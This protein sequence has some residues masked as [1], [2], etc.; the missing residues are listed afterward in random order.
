MAAKLHETKD[1]PTAG[2]GPEIIRML[3]FASSVAKCRLVRRLRSD[4][5]ARSAGFF[6]DSSSEPSL[7]RPLILMCPSITACSL[8]RGIEA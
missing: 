6:T 2:L 5:T 1:L 7:A 4:S 3:F 8:L